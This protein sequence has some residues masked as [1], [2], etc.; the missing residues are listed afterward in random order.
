MDLIAFLAVLAAL[1]AYV[2]A[3]LYRPA[4]Q[5]TRDQERDELIRTRDGL[6]ESLR[7][8]DRE[9]AEGLVPADD[10]DTQRSDLELRAARVMRR[11]EAE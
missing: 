10:Y 3:P 9:L 7:E 8:L 11:L 5:P 2:A 1:T 4:V 6:L